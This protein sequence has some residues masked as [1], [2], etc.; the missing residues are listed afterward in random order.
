MNMSMHNISGDVGR[1]NPEPQHGAQAGYSVVTT[2][3]NKIDLSQGF[4]FLFMRCGFR[5]VRRTVIKLKA[6]G[7]QELSV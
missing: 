1:V 6:K 3:E 4:Y 5:R 2:S 7:K